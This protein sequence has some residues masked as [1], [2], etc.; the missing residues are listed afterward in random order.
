MSSPTQR[1]LA[2]MRSRG[3]VCDI[4][5]RWI[6]GAN[7]KRDLFGFLDLL[8]VVADPDSELFAKD[9]II[10]V[11]VTSD[12]GGNVAARIRK[13]VDNVNVGPVRKAGIRVLV[14]GWRKV[15]GRWRLREVDLS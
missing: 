7:I 15:R 13:I 11:Q 1:S 4:V 10:A 2:E 12:N 8:C 3:Y 6:P 5:E 9:P 14:H